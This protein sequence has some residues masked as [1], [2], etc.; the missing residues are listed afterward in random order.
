[1]VALRHDLGERFSFRAQ[2]AAVDWNGDGLMD[3]VAGTSWGVDRNTGP[4]VGIA[5]YLRYRGEDGAL[6]LRGPSVLRLVSGE[7][8]RTPIPYHHGFTA[9]DWDGDGDIDLFGSEK[10][11][12]VLYRN[13]GGRFRREPVLFYGTPLSVSHHETSV[14]AVD[15]DGDGRLDLL[16]GGE[17]GRVYYFH[18]S[19]LEA[20][21]RPRIII[22]PV[23]RIA[24]GLR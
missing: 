14:R 16:L 24:D 5:V 13:E 11:N 9:V 23:G 6:R 15:W 3:L 20:R 1:M 21:E 12:V 10:S 4:D 17:S 7:E 8:M 18:R 22:G 2:P 19:T